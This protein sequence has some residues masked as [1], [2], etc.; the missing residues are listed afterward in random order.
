MWQ[1]VRLAADYDHASEFVS[2]I[3]DDPL[4]PKPSD[5]QC[6]PQPRR[7]AGAMATSHNATLASLLSKT[8][9][10]VLNIYQNGRLSQ[11][12]GQTLMDKLKHPEF[13]PEDIQ[14]ITIVQLLRR[15]ERPFKDTAV[16]TYDFWK[17]GDRD[18]KLEMVVRDYLEVFREIM[19]DPRWKDEFDFVFRAIFD[20]LGNGMIGPPCSAL[21][22][23]HIQKKL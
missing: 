5:P 12:Q 20:D 17:E 21:H 1:D 15:L 3:L 22:W 10:M 13:K 9:I 11:R 19:R 14:S 2:N 6:Q 7:K 23:E 4:A 8:E 16:V 18:K